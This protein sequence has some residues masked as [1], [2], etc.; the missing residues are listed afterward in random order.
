MRS[1][2]VK[3]LAAV[4]LVCAAAGADQGTKCAART[5][6]A[7]RPAVTLVE[8]VLVLRYAENEGAFLSLGAGF[9]RP[10]RTVVFIAFPVVV[11]GCMI[12]YLFR[13]GGVS[14]GSLVGFSLI[15][16]G[17]AGNL[18]DRLLRDGRVTDFIMVGIGGLHTGIFNFADL[19]VLAGCLVLFFSAEDAR[20]RIRANAKG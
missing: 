10:V 15:V 13:R 16:G 8:R 19:A 2:A 11:L 5:W 20:Q 6:L 7:G 18:I 4:V 3:A 1:P 9:S 14:G 17:G 12:A